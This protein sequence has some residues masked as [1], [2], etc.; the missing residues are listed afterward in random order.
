[1]WSN[2]DHVTNLALDVIPY[3]QPND[4]YGNPYIHPQRPNTSVIHCNNRSV[5]YTKSLFLFLLIKLHQ[6][7]LLWSTS[8]YKRHIPQDQYYRNCDCSSYN[9][10]LFT[11]LVIMD[12]GSRWFSICFC[13]GVFVR[14]FCRIFHFAAHLIKY[15]TRGNYSQPIYYRH[16]T[17]QPQQQPLPLSIAPP[18][19]P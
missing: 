15:T 9:N 6:F 7:Y 16:T 3:L 4:W 10:S 12:K 5:H 1:M 19:A 11:S 18:K 17:A 13:S 14:A 2:L 8:P